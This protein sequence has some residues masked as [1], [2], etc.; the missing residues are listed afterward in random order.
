MSTEKLSYADRMRQRLNKQ[1]DIDSAKS[2]GNSLEM[3]IKDAGSYRVRILP[4]LNEDDHVYATHS[5]HF[6]PE[7]GPSGKG[8]YVF[9]KKKYNVDGKELRCPIDQA[10]SEWYDTKDKALMSEAGRIKRKR[11]YYFQVINLDETDPDKKFRILIDTT[12]EGKLARVICAAM[13]LPFY[14][15]I[16]DGWV[17]KDTEDVDPDFKPVDLVDPTV[18]HD[19]KIV[20]SKTGKNPW[21]ISF[22]KSFPLDERELDKEE[23]AVLEQRV[24]L[25]SYVNYIEDYSTVEN[26]LKQFMGEESA[27]EAKAPTA[28]PSEAPKAAK[29][30]PVA[31]GTDVDDDDLL[32][33]L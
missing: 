28:T 26:Y 31:A 15:D 13:G 4:P 23:E 3:K 9:S 8:M 7:I 10:V 27:D 32:A 30:A 5:Y 2:G 24:D 29:P 33:E 16:E 14:R 25:K 11:Q 12:N 20:K 19:F 17:D 6:V 22:E 1:A 21:D 18:G